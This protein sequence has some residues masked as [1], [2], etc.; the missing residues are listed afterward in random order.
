MTKG[1]G[2]GTGIAGRSGHINARIRGVQECDGHRLVPRR[3]SAADGVVDHIYHIICDCLIDCRDRGHVGAQARTVRI[4]RIAD[5]ESDDVAARRD[6]GYVDGG[7]AERDVTV[8]AGGGAGGMAAVAVVVDEARLVRQAGH[9]TCVRR[10][11]ADEVVAADQLVVAS[12]LV[13]AASRTGAEVIA[14]T[15]RIG[16]LV[17]EAV[18]GR[19]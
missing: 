4:A 7:T 5:V 18:N 6:A 3:G 13:N 10:R 9:G 11:A 17:A 15:E 2:T 14:G 12:S 8:V 19:E 1:T 16:V